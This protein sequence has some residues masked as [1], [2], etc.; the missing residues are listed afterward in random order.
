MEENKAFLNFSRA[1]SLIRNLELIRTGADG[2]NDLS[3][4]VVRREDAVD[5]RHEG[6]VLPH[7]LVRFHDRQSRRRREVDVSGGTNGH[8]D[9][10]LVH[11]GLAAADSDR[12]PLDLT[13][14]GVAEHAVGG[15]YRARRLADTELLHNGDGVGGVAARINLERISDAGAGGQAERGEIHLLDGA[16]EAG[17]DEVGV[18][19]HDLAQRIGELP[20]GRDPPGLDLDTCGDFR[21]RRDGR[22]ACVGGDVWVELDLVPCDASVFNSSQ[23]LVIP[24]ALSSKHDV[25]QR[26]WCGIASVFP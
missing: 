16:R 25:V 11:D 5:A 22:P 4:V 19:G 14:A 23:S 8:L 12:E 7:G 2:H 15:G 10:V 1:R 13:E 21:Q 24:R 17:D 6:A 26:T 9:A 3:A 18:F 20:V